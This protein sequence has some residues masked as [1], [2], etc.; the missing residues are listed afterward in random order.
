MTTIKVTSMPKGYHWRALL[1]DGEPLKRAGRP[2]QGDELYADAWEA[3]TAGHSS[4]ATYDPQNS[5]IVDEII[6]HYAPKKK[7]ATKK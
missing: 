6:A 1:P 2:V 5:Y 3:M 7:K 4:I